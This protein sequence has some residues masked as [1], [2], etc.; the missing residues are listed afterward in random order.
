MS[1]SALSRE[2]GVVLALEM[3]RQIEAVKG[4]EGAKFRIVAAYRDYYR[5]GEPQDNIV[6]RY[7]ERALATGNPRLLE[8]FTSLLSE[9]VASC[10]QGSVPDIGA[11]EEVLESERLD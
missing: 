6:Q 11:Y 8:G 2:D 7:F 5:K 4:E 10:V 9:Y 3:L 1:A